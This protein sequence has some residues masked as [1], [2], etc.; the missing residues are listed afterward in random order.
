M[1]KSAIL[2]AFLAVLSC[3]N[4]VEP[5][6]V[7][8]PAPALVSTSPADGTGGIEG[9]SLSIAFTFDQ[10]IVC[11]S[12]GVAGISVD[13]G[14]FIDKVSPAGAALTV[15]V[16]GLARGKHYTV[17]VPAGAIRGFKR[18]QQA[19]GAITFRFSTKAPDPAPDPGSW[20]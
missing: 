8:V 10:N 4:P 5:E 13:G 14:A 15:V 18:D 7:E 2:A 17:S 1:K 12:S 9:P 11:T 19:S 3:G 16:S 20:E 6:P